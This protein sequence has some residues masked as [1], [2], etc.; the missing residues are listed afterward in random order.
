MHIYQFH[1]L[2]Q[3]RPELAEYLCFSERR[4]YDMCTF[5]WFSMVVMVVSLLIELLYIEPNYY[6]DS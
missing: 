6:W 1:N 2:F 4:L 3:G 5:W